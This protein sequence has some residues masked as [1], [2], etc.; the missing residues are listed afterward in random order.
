MFI[1]R[2]RKSLSSKNFCR[3]FFVFAFLTLFIN[4]ILRICTQY[5]TTNLH[6]STFFQRKEIYINFSINFFF[7]YG[8][9]QARNQEFLRVGEFSWN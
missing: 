8:R 2:Q 1:P 7:S 6:S 4:F 5:D 3:Q 9:T